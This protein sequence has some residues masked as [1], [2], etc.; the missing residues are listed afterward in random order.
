MKQPRTINSILYKMV[1]FNHDKKNEQKKCEGSFINMDFSVVYRMCLMNHNL[2]SDDKFF[3]FALLW[4]TWEWRKIIFRI[5]NCFL[6]SPPHSFTVSWRETQ[7]LPAVKCSATL[8][9][10]A[11]AHKMCVSHVLFKGHWHWKLRSKPSLCL[12]QDHENYKIVKHL[13][14]LRND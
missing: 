6:L 9:T 2:I 8:H 3:F 14:L 1:N 13:V 7:L 4:L 10:W 11:K 5:G 12:F